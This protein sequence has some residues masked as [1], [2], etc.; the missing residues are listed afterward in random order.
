MSSDA[1]WDPT[2]ADHWARA[3]GLVEVPMFG[4]VRPNDAE[5]HSVLLDGMRASFA[6]SV[7]D[8]ALLADDRLSWTWSANLNHLL[9]IDAKKEV[10]F[11]R[12]WDSPGSIRHFRLPQR[13]SAAS[14]LLAQIEGSA[15]P[16]EAD[17]ILHLLRAFRQIRDSVHDPLH[18]IR[19]L[20]ALLLGT[21]AVLFKQVD[22]E[23]WYSCRTV[24]EA[25][26]ALP[27]LLGDTAELQ[28]VPEQ[29]RSKFVGSLPRQL[30]T[31]D[32]ITGR[33]LRPD[34]LLR[35]ASSQLYQE[36]H[37]AI[38]RGPQIGLFSNVLGGAGDNEKYRGQLQRDVR[39]TPPSLARMLVQKAISNCHNLEHRK[40]IVVLDPACGSGVFLVEALR[41]L[42]MRFQDIDVEV[43]GM[44]V[45][46]V[47]CAVARFCMNRT[48]HE[49]SS[50]NFRISV[51][52]SE[53]DALLED[54][55]SPDII[56]MNPPF[57][58]WDQMTGAQQN[59]V[60][61]TLDTTARGRMD[62]AMA[63]LW[64]A[65]ASIK[66]DAIVASVLPAPL[67]ENKAG[68]KLREKISEVA[69]LALVG[70]F[71]GMGYFRG[72][73]VE[74]AFL[75]A[76]AVGG[77]ADSEQT[78]VLVAKEGSEDAALRALR[79]GV[80]GDNDKHYECFQVPA[81]SF[82]PVSWLP[83]SQAASLLG[84][85]LQQA[86]LPMTEVLF[87]VRQGALTGLNEAFILSSDEY[88]R[89]PGEEQIYFRPAAGNSTIKDGRLVEHEYV[90]YPYDSTGIVFKTEEE[91][92]QKLG[93]YYSWRLSS[94]KSRLSSRP[95]VDDIWW[96]LAEERA[97]QRTETPKLISTYFGDSG[98][99]AYDQHGKFAVVQGYAW[100]WIGPSMN[101]VDDDRDTENTESELGFHDSL[102]PWA[103]LALLNSRVFECVLECFCPRVQGGQFNLSKRYVGKTFLPNLMD[104]SRVL[105]SVVHDLAEIGRL[106]HAGK[107][108]GI[109]GGR[110]NSLAIQA[111]GCP[112]SIWPSEIHR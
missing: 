36:A 45:S 7:A 105:S 30:A 91:L 54:W 43:R 98:S 46:P 16:K 106:M 19:V 55:G 84:Q 49:L 11:L 17:V 109:D 34:L 76:R 103:Y 96:K 65:V 10:M 22:A 75:V 18:S 77:V 102:L 71:E 107:N 2:I 25:I 68:G 1:D 39:Y 61:S 78:E 64:K 32:R 42:V 51:T 80:G 94:L 92:K 72:S 20:N 40:K 79:R 101:N 3:L 47:S 99:F 82:L 5:R 100:W 13:K 57:V 21:E 53:T 60:R 8:H 48:R 27:Q 87:D 35:H 104:D 4:K 58:S 6:I 63:F 29:V 24:G 85:R 90:F 89:L 81:D 97:W 74:T 23:Q 69:K 12:R 28:L 108:D 44:D 31:P 15:P 86:M 56:L 73:I 62:M 14:D 88:R 66:N 37:L 33:M 9:A 83:R 93:T 59:V 52:I 111:Y 67:L 110:L 38:E 95:R 70:R 41:E 112:S 50:T 26:D